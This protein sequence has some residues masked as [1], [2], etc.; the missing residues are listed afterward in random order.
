[1]PRQTA[2]SS[3]STK[4]A[5]P[6]SHGI[7]GIASGVRIGVMEREPCCKRVAD[8]RPG[9]PADDG[10]ETNQQGET[11]KESAIRIPRGKITSRA[12]TPNMRPFE[13]RIGK[14]K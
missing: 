14:A 13:Q 2:R 12:S 8:K 3:Q 5:Q 11:K 10:C 1:M 6:R 9:L 4:K 7:C